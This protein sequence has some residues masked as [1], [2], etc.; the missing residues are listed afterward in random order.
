MLEKTSEYKL[1]PIPEV[2]EGEAFWLMS[3]G[4]LTRH[5]THYFKDIDEVENYNPYEDWIKENVK[6][7]VVC[8][9]GSGT[10]VL[11]HLA[12]YY[13]AKKCIGIEKNNWACVYTKGM[14]PHWDIIHNDFLQMEEWPEADIYIHKGIDEMKALNEKAHKLGKTNW[15]KEWLNGYG[16]EQEGMIDYVSNKHKRTFEEL[17]RLGWMEEYL[18]G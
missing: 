12:E 17:I 14:Y 4:Q 18:N 7:K 13:G 8:D 15:P 10:G 5:N 9:L 2:K 11:L 6:D 16:E 1:L 3:L